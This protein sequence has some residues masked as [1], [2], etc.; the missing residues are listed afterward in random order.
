[1]L[2][3]GGLGYPTISAALGMEFLAGRVVYTLGYTRSTKPGGAGRYYGAFAYIGYVGV[4]VTSVMT[5]YN[6]VMG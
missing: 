1:M 3:I 5:A 6:V 4:L 2:F